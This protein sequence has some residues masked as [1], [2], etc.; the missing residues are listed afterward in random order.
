MTSNNTQFM[1]SVYATKSLNRKRKR[2]P[3]NEN[4]STNQLYQHNNKRYKMEFKTNHLEKIVETNEEEEK[5]DKGNDIKC[6][7]NEEKKNEEIN[8]ENVWKKSRKVRRQFFCNNFP[9]LVIT[10][11]KGR[12]L[13][14]ASS[15]IRFMNIDS[16]YIRQKIKAHTHSENWRTLYVHLYKSVQNSELEEIASRFN[17]IHNKELA[18]NLPK[19]DN[20]MQFVTP[21][22]CI[23]QKS[24]QEEVKKK[25]VE[26]V[27][28]PN[29]NRYVL[30]KNIN[31]RESEKEILDSLAEYK[32][33]VQQIQRFKGLPIV[34]V[35]M[36]SAEEV[37]R[38]LDDNNI[39]IGYRQVKCEIFDQNRRRPRKAFKQCRKCYGLNHIAN[40]CN[41]K[42]ICKYCGKMNHSSDQC[43]FK[44]SPKKHH[45]V[46]C[47]GNHRS[48]SLICPKTKDIRH[49]LG[50]SFTRREN[51]IINKKTNQANSQNQNNN[52]SVIKFK[53]SPN[54]TPHFQN[55]DKQKL[56][57]NQNNNHKKES[58][59]KLGST[60]NIRANKKDNTNN[61]SYTSYKNDE[62]ASLR[63][64][65]ANLKSTVEKLNIFI[66]KMIPLI[67]KN[68]KFGA[69]NLSNDTPNYHFQYLYNHYWS[70][71]GRTGILCRR[72]IHST[73]R[74]FYSH[75]YKFD[76]L[77]YESCWIEV[78]YPGQNKPLLF[79]SI[80]RNIQK[81]EVI[82]QEDTKENKEDS[83]P[84]NNQ[85]FYLCDFEKELSAAKKISDNIII[86]GDWNAHHPAWLD[87][88]VDKIGESIL[89]FI[90]A[91][92]L[93]I[94]NS[95][96][97]DCTYYKENSSSC[98]DV[99][100]CS[101]SLAG[102][103]CDWRTDD[104]ELDAHSDHLPISFNILAQWAPQHI[105]RQKIV[106]WNL[107][108]NGWELFRQYLSNNLKEWTNTL[109]NTSQNSPDAL[110]QAVESWS[111]Y[112]VDTGKATIGQK[113][114]WKGNKPWW[115]NKLHRLRKNV[116]QLKRKF[117][118]YRTSE[119]Y[120]RYKE[121]ALSFKRILRCEK[122]MH[123]TKS[124][125]SLHENN[126]KQMF[127]QFRSLNSNKIAI[128]P[129]LISPETDGVKYA[130]AE[131]DIEKANLLA[132]WFA[133]PPQPPKPSNE[134]KEHYEYVED[135]IC[136][137]V[138]MSKE[139]ELSE[140]YLM[141]AWYQSE[142][143]EEEVIEA[144]RHISAY[145]SQGPDNIHNLMLKN[146]GQSLI[147]SLVLLFGWSYKIGYFPKAWKIANIVAIPKPDR[148]PTICKNYRPISLLSC[149]GKLMERI[150]TMRLMKY[151][152]ENQMLH[153]CQ[154]GFQ[155]WHNTSELLLRLSESI[156][157][158]FDKNG[159]TYAAMLDISSAYDSVWR[160]GLRYKMRN[161]FNL[162]GRLYWWIDSFLSE[163]KGHVVINGTSSSIYNFNTGVPQG[164]SL[165]PLLF[166]LYINDISYEVHEPIQCGMFADD[167]ALWTSIY[168]SNMTE[169]NHQLQLLQQSLDRI[170]LWASK[171]KL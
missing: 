36:P 110:D 21:K 108:S 52:K 126:T 125:E 144:I 48:D 17:E 75:P 38:I 150:I 89:D 165:S 42:S 171:W 90:I 26:D 137:V 94:L 6:N 59:D 78:S 81:H 148:D 153:Q 86:G 134:N 156:H 113:V 170:S 34:K 109:I 16:K 47:K 118:K 71:T 12:M 50:I 40:D 31:I 73:K 114:S 3:D 139:T 145:K 85:A 13:L 107:S 169:M 27:N 112:V 30:L 80:Y 74:S 133:Q 53:T 2:L 88:N 147:N 91:N 32:Y 130:I 14:S 10:P 22:C 142:I 140:W 105:K 103:C 155:S 54:K 93:H 39:F 67:E 132:N 122:Q 68:S 121:A 70:E 20:E 129:S 11:V 65:V 115:S 99:T 138:Q 168:T 146:G 29:V 101:S 160:D 66:D 104:Y 37:K 154:A 33:N 60:S 84:F 143:T 124:I 131:T 100:L 96:P 18:Q 166:L 45:C 15:L 111:Q 8:E 46:L 92:N 7:I 62:I 35:L 24:Y 1:R 120:E 128:I 127:C 151:L 163:R 117:R 55:T 95:Y 167:V 123:I 162:C 4:D 136:S 9:T 58:K 106:T 57:P 79:C 56:P 164:S 23:F 149:V 51:E 161:E 63:A 72:D 159:V 19:D 135:E 44:K 76:M 98:I 25:R 69:I 97:F 157:A 49:K 5:I 102:L 119:N 83:I 61:N 64:E 77:G 28:N 158:S 152:N 82:L 41:K 141:D 87:K 116:H 43:K